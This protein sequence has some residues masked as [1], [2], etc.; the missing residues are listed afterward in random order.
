MRSVLY[1][2][3]ATAT[4]ALL[5]MPEAD[6]ETAC[7]DM[8]QQADLADRY[9]RR[10][11]RLHADWGNGTLLAV[12]RKWPLAPE[13]SFNDPAYRACFSLVLQAL[14]KHLQV[15]KCKPD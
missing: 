1:L 3:V 9:A 5:G 11:G 8:L 13:A 15:W 2:D 7:A 4:R 10:L 6:R 12:A 14:D